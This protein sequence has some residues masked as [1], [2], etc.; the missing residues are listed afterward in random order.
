MDHASRHSQNITVSK[1]LLARLPEFS[2]A[3][4][5]SI[6]SALEELVLLGTIHPGNHRPRTMVVW[7]STSVGKPADRKDSKCVV[8]LFV[9][10]IDSEA[11]RGIGLVHAILQPACLR[12][13]GAARERTDSTY[14]VTII[15]E[16]RTYL[17]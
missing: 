1:H 5:G 2:V 13:R 12:Q 9:Q 17:L 14:D 3:R 11:L 6:V 7:W 10:E 15:F 4:T 8:R 16:S